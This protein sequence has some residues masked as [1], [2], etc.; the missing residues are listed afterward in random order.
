MSPSTHASRAR[1]AAL[2]TCQACDESHLV[3]RL[4][5]C[6]SWLERVKASWEKERAP[7]DGEI[8]LGL[9]QF[10]LARHLQ[11][12]R[13]ANQRVR[14]LERAIGCLPPAPDG[15]ARFAREYDLLLRLP[16]VLAIEVDRQDRI[17][18]ET[19]LIDAP[20]NGHRYRIGRFRIVLE[21]G[22]T[23]TLTNLDAPVSRMGTRVDHPHVKDGTPCLGSA[24]KDVERAVLTDDVPAQIQIALAL[25]RSYNGSSCFAPIAYW[26]QVKLLAPF[27]RPDTAERTTS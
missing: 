21:A 3:Q 25:L 6:R 26:P 17:V 12:R 20:Y 11:L 5:S 24:S 16:G 14:W 18:V 4:Q 7:T 2:R 15:P 13:A 27:K 10:R 23:F 22:R 19:D 8:D 9:Q 1:Y